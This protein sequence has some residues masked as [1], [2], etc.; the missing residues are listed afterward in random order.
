MGDRGYD[1]AY[2]PAEPLLD[3]AGTP[4]YNAGTPAYGQAPTPGGGPYAQGFTP[5]EADAP[6]GLSQARQ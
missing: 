4:G 1:Q 3:R 6:G 5:A 2:T